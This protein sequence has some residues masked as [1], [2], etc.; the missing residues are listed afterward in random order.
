MEATNP[1]NNYEE[2]H[3]YYDPFSID[4]HNIE[5]SKTKIIYQPIPSYK[6]KSRFTDRM[7]DVC[8]DETDL[9]KK[10]INDECASKFHHEPSQSN[11]NMNIES[12][13]ANNGLNTKFKDDLVTP[14][15]KAYF[16]EEDK[17]QI[18]C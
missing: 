11:L 3:E 14:K 8:K 13:P 6:R 2:N 10:R 1:N 7:D 5:G 12:S 18:L 16:T 4:S 9:R 15:S 17:V